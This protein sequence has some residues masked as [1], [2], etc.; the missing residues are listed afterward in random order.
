MMFY[1]FINVSVH[2]PLHGLNDSWRLHLCPTETLV[3][4]SI[5]DITSVS[6]LASSC[7]GWQVQKENNVNPTVYTKLQSQ[8]S[9]LMLKSSLGEKYM[10]AQLLVCLN[11]KN[12][13]KMTVWYNTTIIS[14]VS[15]WHQGTALVVRK[16]TN[17]VFCT[18][19]EQVTPVFA[20]PCIN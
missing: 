3:M 9:C 10:L 16:K 4:G 18:N 15:N 12:G 1:G 13:G 17:T 11:T 20:V 2:T 7:P 19:L 6:W 5:S 8:Y 14:G